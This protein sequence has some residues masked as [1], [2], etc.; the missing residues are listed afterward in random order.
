M[1]PK[2]ESNSFFYDAETLLKLTTEVLY[3]K[4]SQ[5][6]RD[7]C[8][9]EIFAQ[10]NSL[11]ASVEDDGHELPLR[12]R[13]DHDA[14]GN[15]MACCECNATE[16]VCEH[17]VATLM[18]Q[19]HDQ[20]SANIYSARDIAIADRIKRARTEVRVKHL[21]GHPH[22]G[23]WQAGSL[24]TEPGKSRYYDVHIRSLDERL[25]FCT[26][27]D[28]AVNQ[29]GTCK[30]IEAVLHHLDRTP[31]GAQDGQKRLPFVYTTWQ[32]GE[33]TLR[34]Q[35]TAELEP[36]VHTL[37]DRYFDA[38]G[39]FTASL[40][41][42]FFRLRDECYGREDVLIGPDA[43]R[44]AERSAVNESHALQAER[45]SQRIRQADGHVPGLKARL[46]PYQIEGVAFLAGQ[47]RAILADDMGL[48]KTLQAIAATHF[49]INE[50]GVRRVLIVCPA[51][52]K[53]QWAREIEK[54]TGHSVQV[55]QGNA[56]ER[57]V[58]YRQDC[59][60]FVLNY[61][62]VLRDLSL[63]N[64][65]LLPDLLILDEAQR[66][67]NWRTRIAEAIKGIRSRY[68]F[69]LSGTPLENRLEDLYS[70]MQV[71]DQ[72]RLGPLWRYFNDFHVCD[73]KGRV[74]GYR[75]LSELRRRI[76]PVM[77]RRNRSIVSQQLPARTTTRIDIELT[78]R[79][80]ELH[81]GALNT[82]GKLAK[83]N[84]S[85]PLTPTEQKRLMSAL[86]SARMACDAAG[87]VDGET[88]GSPKLDELRT[89][90]QELC[91]DGGQKMV[92]FSQWL[93]MTRMVE[94]LLQKMGV[95]CVH[96]NGQVPVAKRGGLMDRF[97]DDD[98]VSVF[99]STDAG[100]SGLNLQSASVLV[101]MDI[102]W[103]PAVLEQRNARIHRLG[104]EKRV[105]II[106]LVAR[107]A[108][109]ERVL[110]LVSNKQELFDSVVD[111]E[112]TEDVVGIS[113]KA[114]T[115]LISE[116]NVLAHADEPSIPRA[117]NS[118][119]EINTEAE[120]EAE[121]DTEPKPLPEHDDPL[122]SIDDARLR[123]GIAVLQ[124]RFGPRLL[125]VLAEGGALVAVL[126]MVVEDDEAFVDGLA[127]PLPVLV[128]DPRTEISLQRL[129]RITTPVFVQPE[130]LTDHKPAPVPD[131]RTKALARVDAASVLLAQ[132]ISVGI[133]DLLASALGTFY[134]DATPG[135]QPLSAEQL[136][137]WLYSEA[138]P[139]QRLDTHQAGIITRILTLRQVDNL[140][141]GLLEES[142]REARGLLEAC[143]SN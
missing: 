40:P 17:S 142:V 11:Y 59:R 45:L 24:N 26:C 49:L 18:Q 33:E 43:V 16:P 118:S 28:L 38:Q 7:H 140:P 86:Q 107:N 115:E 36:A 103:N 120:A 44:L 1:I 93:G 111:P 89:L 90:V 39:K 80:Q 105:Q 130:R 84:A 125:R 117:G 58:Q 91:I 34:V 141:A 104:Q 74:L 63:I 32:D 106:L 95:G 116:L 108:Y 53:H 66:V 6:F 20:D 14:E 4:G 25:N 112:A 51:S 82:A 119:S 29:L 19:V 9:V 47:G 73:E 42:D 123:T 10:D 79:Q 22:F 87:L 65:Q 128:I 134:A 54:F 72:Y 23:I 77:L 85:R 133:M 69:V 48:G 121:V 101:N 60:F 30:H 139:Q 78:P 94:A 71:V 132:N 127:L 12:V 52:L 68:A 129:G 83:I 143:R 92:V 70:L 131:W 110:Q 75:N 99:I 122:A 37:L 57:M 114:I 21:R 96:L 2:P 135:S 126:D 62:L 76:A 56:E 109:E 27:P 13:L 15:L 35:R 64:E 113:K 61:E 5:L 98:A 3:R 8:V 81:D 31:V 55:V 41:E 124:R 88:E 136:T 97:R 102:P 138:L 50:A 46:F 137:L 67:K 100:G